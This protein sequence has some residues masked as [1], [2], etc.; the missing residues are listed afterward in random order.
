MKNFTGWNEEWEKIAHIFGEKGFPISHA[1]LS[2][3]REAYERNKQALLRLFPEGGRIFAESEVDPDPEEVRAILKTT[4][5]GSRNLLEPSRFDFIKSADEGEGVFS[6]VEAFAQIFLT[7]EEL[8]KNRL[9]EDK[10]RE[11]PNGQKLNKGMK[12]SKALGQ[13]MRSSDNLWTSPSGRFRSYPDDPPHREL[14]MELA[15]IYFSVILE[16]VTGLEK[17]TVVL[18]VNPLDILLQADY[19]SGGWSSCHRIGGPHRTGPPALA[20]DDAT[21]IAFAYRGTDMPVIGAERGAE[22]FPYP[23]KVWRQLIFMAPHQQLAYQGREYKAPAPRLARAARHMVGQIMCDANGSEVRKWKVRGLS[24]FAPLIKNGDP[25]EQ[26]YVLEEGQR[27]SRR[28]RWYYDDPLSVRIRLEEITNMDTISSG[29][30]FLPC[31][32][33]GHLRDLEVEAS[34]SNEENPVVTYKCLTCRDRQC[35]SC[36]TRNETVKVFSLI[37][38]AETRGRHVLCVSCAHEAIRT[39]SNCGENAINLYSVSDNI[40]NVCAR[41]RDYFQTLQEGGLSDCAT[42]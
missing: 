42:T 33:C 18:S 27:V 6:L 30:L 12:A 13:F 34:H 9:E 23:L 15:S 31:W 20:I 22:G 19:T 36:G 5:A 41:C 8:F 2:A 38:S 14:A 25:D 40:R 39:C 3:L 37:T 4:R 7:T 10:T 17:E 16:A 26:D 1:G 35:Q 11:L 32:K 29:V 28:S 24:G 21:M